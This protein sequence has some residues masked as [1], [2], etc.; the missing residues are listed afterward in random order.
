MPDKVKLSVWMLLHFL[1]ETLGGS[2]T[3]YCLSFSGLYRWIFMQLTQ[4]CFYD[5]ICYRDLMTSLPLQKYLCD[6]IFI[7]QLLKLTTCSTWN[8]PFTV[9]LPFRQR[10]V[11]NRMFKWKRFDVSM[12]CGRSL[13]W[14]P[15][16][17]VLELSA[18]FYHRQKTSV[19]L[20]GRQFFCNPLLHSWLMT[21]KSR[22]KK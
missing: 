6:D 3:G 18:G 8:C 13:D 16:N 11:L 19:H 5:L 12:A 20:F 21:A 10:S 1:K 22:L 15:V 14:R 9:N 7:L 4:L 17:K 2:T